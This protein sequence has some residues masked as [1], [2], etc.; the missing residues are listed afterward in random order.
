MAR[1]YAE[2]DEYILVLN[3]PR[4]DYLRTKSDS[5]VLLLFDAAA[6]YSSAY[7]LGK[8]RARAR[9]MELMSERLRHTHKNGIILLRSSQEEGS[10]LKKQRKAKLICEQHV[11]LSGRKY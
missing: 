3:T 11:M 5:L 9:E 7:S 2:S 10:E 6:A 1:L 8:G 4:N